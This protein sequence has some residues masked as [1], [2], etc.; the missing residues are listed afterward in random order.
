MWAKADAEATLPAHDLDRA[1]AFYSERL[2]LIPTSEDRVGIH[3][4]VGG[5]RFRLFKSS[6]VASGSHTQ[7]A[8]I[9]A[10][11][12]A[13]VAALKARGLLFEEYDYPTLK[14]IGSVAD[15]AYAKAAWF[16]DSEG[17]LLGLAQVTPEP[18]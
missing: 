10:D 2:G 11:V 3:F 6:G 8:F 14:T 7:L 18:A 5:T 1:R 9:V 17:N 15:L 16:K 12:G 4:I 13:Q